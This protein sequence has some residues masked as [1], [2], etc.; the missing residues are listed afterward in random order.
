MTADIDQFRAIVI[1]RLAHALKAEGR[2]VIHMEFGQPSTG[3]PPAAIAEAHR[4]LDLDGMGYWESAPLKARIVQLYRDRYG[5]TVTPD[6]LLLTCG[7]SPALV[8]ALSSAFRPGDRIA[9]AR[10]GYVAYRNTV[11]ALNMEA[12]EI[13]CGPAEHY[14]LTAAALD[15]LHPA[16]AG[17]IIA[18]PANPTGSVISVS[19]L[20]EIAAVCRKKRIRILSDEIYHGLSYVEPQ[21]SMLSFEPD[22]MVINSFSKYWS[23]AGWRLGWLLVPADHAERARAFIGNLFLTPPSLSQHAGLI[24]MDQHDV[25]EG[26]IEVYRR[27]RARMLEALP[28]LGLKSIAPPD[29]AFYI[30]A[31]IGHLT[32]DSVAF[33]ERLLRDTG[34]ATAPGV[35]FDPVDGHRF[36]RFS[37]AVSTP[38]IEDALARMIPWFAARAAD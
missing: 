3:A 15:A 13:A 6:R 17:V 14:Q 10:P 26:H 4:V 23:M 30:W 24:A 36:M 27:N 11:R 19:E 29:G 38:E 7:A 22:A 9:M 21:P 1:S 2:S 34:V 28:A 20:S 25:L 35:D 31:D 8:L 33:C 16:P 12:V 5:V 37:F 32:Q 18:S